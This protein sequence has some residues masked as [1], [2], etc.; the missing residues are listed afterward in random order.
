MTNPVQQG[1]HA[2][3]DLSDDELLRYSRHILLD[4]IGIEGQSRISNAKV[5]IVGAGGLGCPVGL[6]MAAAGVGEI[7]IADD[8]EVDLTN[9]QRQVLHTTDRVGMPKVES[10][11][12]QM[13]A[14]NPTIR[15]NAVQQRLTGKALSDA[16][17]NADLVLDCCDNFKTRHAVNAACVE[18]G[19]PLVS[20]AAIRLD[21]QLACFDLGNSEAPCYHCL[22]PD[23]QDVSEINCATMGVLAPVTG[24]IGTLQ[25]TEALK[26][27]AGFGSPLFGVLQIYDARNGDF[28]RMRVPKD[29]D[30]PVCNK[31][32]KKRAGESG[33]TA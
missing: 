1:A 18:H 30:C 3:R 27:I 28:T 8:D 24:V 7:T 17:Q 31:A 12:V 4:D 19:K 20:G 5:L 25:A 15:V 2:L 16:V 13:L 9:L 22:F 26:I 32:T 14:L 33:Q 11:K 29:P 21:G 23:G 10:A 6:Y